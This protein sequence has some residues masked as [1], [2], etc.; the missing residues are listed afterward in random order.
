MAQSGPFQDAPFADDDNIP[1]CK[2]CGEPDCFGECE[3][4]EINL[5][6]AYLDEEDAIF[7]NLTDDE[8][9]EMFG[10]EDDD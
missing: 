5:F 8:Q 3:D 2:F 1:G 9:D 6:D 7:D 10:D 4:D